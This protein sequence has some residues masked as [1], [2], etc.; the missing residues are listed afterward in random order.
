MLSSVLMS[1]MFV[2]L[3]VTCVVLSVCYVV[4]VTYVDAGG[5]CY[6]GII[7]DVVMYCRIVGW[8]VAVV[9]VVVVCYV[10]GVV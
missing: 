6:V 7:D 8:G 3:L 4:V 2:L 9:V 1:V 10:V 5:V